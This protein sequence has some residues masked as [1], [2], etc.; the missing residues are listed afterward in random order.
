ML[1]LANL[2]FSYNVL[3]SRNTLDAKFLL[4]FWLDIIK[5]LKLKIP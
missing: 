4:L 5:P 1:P 2:F 3:N